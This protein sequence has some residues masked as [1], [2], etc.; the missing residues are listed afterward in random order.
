LTEI[1]WLIL[2]LHCGSSYGQSVPNPTDTSYI[3]NL[4]KKGEA[5]ETSQP[6]TALNNY[7]KAHTFSRKINYTK[8]YF[9]SMRLLAYQLNNMG[10]HAEAR[11]VAL[12]AVQKAKQDTSK[13][14]LGLS[15]FAVANTAL[16]MGRYQE[17]IPNYQNAVLYMRQIGNLKNVSVVN[18]NL[19]F[20]FRKQKM[21]DKAIDYY[22]K[23]LALDTT[24]TKENADR[25]S[26]ASDYFSIGVV[27]SDLEKP[28]E[29][30]AYYQKAKQWINPKNDLD[31]MVNLYNN[32]GFEHGLAHRYDSALYYRREAL[33]F[34][35]LLGNDRHELHILMTI[36]ETYNQMEQYAKARKLLDESYALALKTAASLTEFQNIY[37]E[38]AVANDGL[39]NYEATVKWLDKFIVA[40]DSLNNEDT[41]SLL[42][43]YEVKLKQAEAGQQLAQKQRSIDQLREQQQRQN[44]W[45]VVAILIAFGMVGALVFTYLYNRQR[46]RAADNALLATEREHELAVVQSELQGQQKERLR[47]SKEMH[48]DLGA[49]LT[50]IGLLSEVVKTRMG[51]ATTP[52]VEKISS[53]SAD[54]VTSMN[55]IIWSLNTKNDSLNGLI[56]YTRSYASEFIDNTSLILRTEVEESSLE[57]PMRG[58]D[59]RNVF[60]T[61]KEALNNVVKHA[62]AT[63]I[64]L[65]MIPEATQLTIEVC[66]NG[67]GFTPSSKASLRNGL[68]NMQN[69]MTESG[70]HCEILPSPTGTCVKITYPY[71]VVATPKILQT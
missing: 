26:I 37:H 27:Y 3:M 65:R 23:A 32:I 13:R 25:R 15:Y 68:G 35:R 34:S 31:F 33:R 8:G 43:E 17:A 64:T 60:L 11:K 54:M 40:T 57:I 58:V 12:A 38:Y 22:R 9:E 24:W 36:A 59:R 19:G 52:E 67:R 55:E 46:Q 51:A 47:I 20:I 18:Q 53:I 63:Q 28:R 16:F 2:S 56:A 61:V 6:A 70:G 10:R 7:Q 62:Q 45:L 1:L 44:L 66:D 50:A 5:V 69:R 49:S 21:Y 39:G 42:Q 4:L 71:P 30:L 41:K 29:A 48:D 14:Y